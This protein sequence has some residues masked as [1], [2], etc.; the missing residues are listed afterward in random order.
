MDWYIR[1]MEPK[2]KSEYLRFIENWIKHI[3][4]EK[5]FEWLYE[6]NP[7]GRAVTYLVIHRKNGNIIGST[8][9]FPKEMS[10]M[11][12]R[13]FRAT[14][15][16]DTFVDPAY[17]RQGIARKLHLETLNG[18]MERNMEFHFG[19]PN[20]GNFKALLKAGVLSPGNFEG[21]RLVLGCEP[22]IEKLRLGA[23]AERVLGKMGNTLFSISMKGKYKFAHESDLHIIHGFD[24]KFDKLV[25]EV[26][27]DHGLCCSRGAEYLK[28]RYI[29][30][31][32]HESTILAYE[33]EDTLHGFAV[34]RIRG[35]K[36][37]LV[38]FFSR[39]QKEYVEKLIHAVI[40]FAI[41]RGSSLITLEAN[42]RGLYTESFLKCGFRFG[43]RSSKYPLV[44]FPKNGPLDHEIQ[45]AVRNLDNWYLTFGDQD[46][47]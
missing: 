11:G 19:F 34:V 36:C 21:L 26:L 6:R 2:D 47:E 44:V 9:L 28:W 24:Q 20:V 22:F 14:L 43:Y 31:P 30:N 18:L 17:R 25:E 10:W 27:P 7:H 35:W 32:L 41:S 33:E 16:G 13:R 23:V 3:P 38:D 45:K 15:G 42:P 39:S 5:R 37:L 8:S 40:A 29:D 46:R 4:V 1:L 12:H